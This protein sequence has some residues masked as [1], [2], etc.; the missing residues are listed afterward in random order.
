MSSLSQWQHEEGYWVGDY[1]L[2]GSGGKPIKDEDW[3]YPFDSYKAFIT[4]NVKG[5]KYRQRSVLM[6]NRQESQRGFPCGAVV[7]TGTCGT[8]GNMKIFQV[9]QET[10]TCS[11][12]PELKGDIEGP[13]GQSLYTTTELIGRDNA[14][15]YQVWITKAGLNF[16]EGE[17]LG[18]PNG[19]CTGGPTNWDCGYTSDRLFESQLTTITTVTDGGQSVVHRTRTKQGFYWY[20]SR[21]G[22]IGATSY[23]SYYRETKVSETE[24]WTQF[25][26]TKL[27]YTILDSDTCA[28]TSDEVGGPA[29]ATGLTP[30]VDACRAHFEESF[31]L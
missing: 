21:I 26:A 25:D 10:T 18:N 7:G 28:W 19:R 6:Y 2:Y 3:N 29:T 16:Y 17:T 11:L 5:N 15:L 30:G 8:N 1:S 23:A 14:L 27:A 22:T 12:N 9:D 24:F 13:Y 31:E 4:G 20:E